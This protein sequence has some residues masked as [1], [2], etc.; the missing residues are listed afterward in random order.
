LAQILKDPFKKSDYF[1]SLIQGLD[2]EGW[3]DDIHKWLKEARK[4]QSII[5][6]GQNE[7]DHVEREFKKAFIDYAEHKRSNRELNA[8]KMTENNVD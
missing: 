3:A 8:L 6:H 4:D 5:Q 7:W 1:L 2:T